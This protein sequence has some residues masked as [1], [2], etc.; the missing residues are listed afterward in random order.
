MG[1]TSIPQYQLLAIDGIGIRVPDTEEN[2][3]LIGVH[4]NQYG[5][6]AA[7][8]IL[9]IHDVLNRVFYHVHLHPRS[10]AELVALHQKFE[11][12]PSNSIMIYDRHYCDSLLLDRHLKS[13]KPCLIRMKIKGIKAV[14]N[15]LKSGDTDSIVEFRL[16]ERAYYSA[17]DKYGLKNKH[18]KFS[19]FKIRLLRVELPNGTTEVLATNLLDKN[20]FSRE[21]FKDLYSKRWGEE[22]AFDELKNQLKLGVFSGYKAQFVLQDLWSVLIFYNI[23][24]MFIHVAEKELNGQK[25]KGQINRN[26]AITIVKKDWFDLLLSEHQGVYV[27]AAINLIKRYYESVRIRPPTKRTRKQMR[28]NERYMTEKNYKPAF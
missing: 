19:T 8:K 22:T 15:F 14:E 16:G 5:A 17:R 11:I 28:L 26:I 12:L 20:K 2:R 23:R 21:E 9:A 4:K 25:L 3:C 27:K 6:I 24:S 1:Y 13:R 10:V 18:P 7:C